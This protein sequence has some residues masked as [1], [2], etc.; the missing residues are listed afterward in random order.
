MKEKAHKTLLK[1]S[2]SLSFLLI[3][4]LLLLQNFIE[5]KL[6]TIKQA[7]QKLTNSI[8]KIQGSITKIKNYEERQ[9]LQ[10]KDETGEIKAILPE[11]I[12]TEKLKNKTL[13]I[14]GRIAEYKGEKEIFIEKIREE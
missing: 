9:I 10:I 4:L 6:I 8:I 5:P 11:K 7:K 12:K 1:L 13:I 14:I 3:F 2:L